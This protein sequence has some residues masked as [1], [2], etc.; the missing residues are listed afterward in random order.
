[1]DDLADVRFQVIS[2]TCVPNSTAVLVVTWGDVDREREGSHAPEPVANFHPQ[3]V[4]AHDAGSEGLAFRRFGRAT[5]DR[6]SA[7]HQRTRAGA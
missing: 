1:M 7:L 5:D 2:R 3:Q 6:R 4:I